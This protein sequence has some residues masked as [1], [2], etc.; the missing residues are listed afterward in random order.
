MVES[1]PLLR[2][3][4]LIAY[5]GFESLRLCQRE[6]KELAT[7]KKAT[8]S[9]LVKERRVKKRTSIGH[10]TR[11]SYKGKHGRKAKYRGQG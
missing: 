7:S 6:D 10:S 8:A 2:V 4:T 1:T 3:H 11:S 5:R 9:D